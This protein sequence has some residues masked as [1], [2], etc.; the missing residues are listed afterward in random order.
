M[1]RDVQGRAVFRAAL[2]IT[3]SIL[4]CTRNRVDSLRQT[5]L[6]VSRLTIP[7]TMRAELVVVDN[8]SSDGTS[9]FLRELRIPSVSVVALREESPGVG[10]ARNAALRASTGDILL[11]TDDDTRLPENWLRA[12]CDP[13]LSGSA[14]AVAG[15]VALAPNLER[16]WMRPQ[17]R[18]ILAAT[19]RL[20]F[21]NPQEMFGASMA[22]SR[23]VLEKVPGFDPEL[24]P[25]TEVGGMEDTLFSW[26][27]R[28]AGF[29][30][31]ATTEAV[32]EHH[33]DEARLS[34]SSY[35]RG[36]RQYGRSLAYIYY[37]WLHK[38][39]PSLEKSRSLRLNL[40][41]RRA[42]LFLRRLKRGLMGRQPRPEGLPRW[43]LLAI[44]RLEEVRQYLKER[45][46]DHNYDRLGL[47]KRH[48]PAVEE[49]KSRGI[50]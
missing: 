4:I 1:P 25:G 7:E 26:Q 22:F 20:D 37:H 44:Q 34:R 14:D 23:R 41:N 50:K 15:R 13:I 6:S 27:I 16:E 17:H 8:G 33:P 18:A 12:L 36:A 2:V 42:Q 47:I 24:G 28:Q 30:I 40:V 3:V 5:L 45:R 21:E 9:E 32:V 38:P 39:P 10:S 46:R 35:V 43:E 19:D 31:V 48:R 49:R 11:F 29:R